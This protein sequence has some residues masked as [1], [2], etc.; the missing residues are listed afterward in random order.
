M[1]SYIINKYMWREVKIMMEKFIDTAEPSSWKLMSSRLTVM[2]PP[3]DKTRLSN[4]GD[5]GKA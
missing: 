5:S 2:K 4:V 1:I 3:W